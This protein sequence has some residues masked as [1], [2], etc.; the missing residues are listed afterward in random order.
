MGARSE[1]QIL[2]EDMGAVKAIAH[3]EAM[4]WHEVAAEVQ[5]LYGFPVKHR[6]SARSLHLMVAASAIFTYG[7]LA[8]ILWG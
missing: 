8:Y 3:A 2:I 5:H 4:G 7:G 1:A 6:P